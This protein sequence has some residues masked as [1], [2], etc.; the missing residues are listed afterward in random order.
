MPDDLVRRIEALD[1]AALLRSADDL[2]AVWPDLSFH[3]ESPLGGCLLITG[4]GFPVNRVTAL[5]LAGPVAESDLVRIEAAFVSRGLEPAVDLSPAD[6]PSLQ[7][8]LEVRGYRVDQRTRVFAMDPAELADAPDPPGVRIERVSASNAGEFEFVVARGFRD[9]DD[10]DPGL[11]ART[12]SR[13]V[14][15]GRRG[16][17][18]LARVEGEPAGGGVVGI[19]ERT[20]GLYGASTLPRFRGRGVQSALL[21]HRV[22]LARAEGCDLAYVRTNPDT[23]SERNVRRAGFRFVYEKQEWRRKVGG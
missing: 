14:A 2:A 15:L 7:A 20:A 23:G 9:M 10:G 22:R 11:P 1:A 12:F 3:A 18:F 6:H 21:R 5:G 4:E 8:L 16:P 17:G 13:V 19:R